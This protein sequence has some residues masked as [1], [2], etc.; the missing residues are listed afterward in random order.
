MHPSRPSS[1]VPAADFPDQ[2]T[3]ASHILFLPLSGGPRSFYS[4]PLKPD[5]FLKPKTCVPLLRKTATE[6]PLPK[7]ALKAKQA[8]G[9]PGG[10]LKTRAPGPHPEFLTQQGGLGWDPIFCLPNKVPGA[11]A[12]L[13]APP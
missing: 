8:P 5:F 12:G 3:S 9:S 10:L 7:T 1:N 2:T 6:P 11:A 4:G 13:R